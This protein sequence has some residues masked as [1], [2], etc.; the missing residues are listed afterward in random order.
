MKF[1][2]RRARK[3]ENAFSLERSH[4][5][6]NDANKLFMRHPSASQALQVLGRNLSPPREAPSRIIIFSFA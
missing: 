5:V 6:I 3:G 2:S 4:Y 1:S